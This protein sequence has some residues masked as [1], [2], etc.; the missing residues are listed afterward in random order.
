MKFLKVSIGGG[1]E[2]ANG[3]STGDNIFCEYC[4]NLFNRK[5]SD[6]MYNVEWDGQNNYRCKICNEV[7]PSYQV[8]EH[9]RNHIKNGE[10]LWLTVSF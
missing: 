4:H 6:I 5:E 7:M 10:R 9:V 1:D 2:K 3:W 8:R